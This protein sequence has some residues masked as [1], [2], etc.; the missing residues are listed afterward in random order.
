MKKNL[1][2]ISFI[3]AISSL[4]HPG[5]CDDDLKN[6]L[7]TEIV[8]V[9]KAK[10]NEDQ[11]AID[12]IVRADRIRAPEKPFGYQLLL[13][14]YRANKLANKQ[15]LDVSMRF[16][17]PQ[18]DN[19]D[20]DARALIRF[21]APVR[22]KGKRILSDF[23]KMWYFSPELRNPIP[24]SRQQRLIG[25]VSNGDVVA[26]DFDLSYIAQLLGEEACDGKICYKLH[27]ERRN[28]QVTYP[29]ITYW[30]E[31]ETYYPRQ[32][33]FMSSSGVLIKRSYYKDYRKALDQIR[34]HQIIIED[35]LQKENYTVMNYS[36]LRYESLPENYFQKEY[37]MRMK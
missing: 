21:L 32:A 5:Y 27:L 31:K 35:S 33:D 37:L 13:E 8:K 3:V 10:Q 26:T 20:F 15:T 12:I 9:R 11:Q 4:C 36:N 30:V 25:Q 34:P 16:F 6:Q 17:K 14:E 24:I 29:S 1:V 18:G 7:A 23:D 19:S 28:P 2:N 22:D